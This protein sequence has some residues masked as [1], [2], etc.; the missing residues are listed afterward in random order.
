MGLL[1]IHKDAMLFNDLSAAKSKVKGP[2][3]GFISSS[4]QIQ[5]QSGPILIQIVVDYFHLS[6]NPLNDRRSYAQVVG[7]REKKEVGRKKIGDLNPSKVCR[8]KCFVV[9][10]KCIEEEYKKNDLIMNNVAEEKLRRWTIPF[11]G[12][13]V[14]ST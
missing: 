10:G 1:H 14:R 6:A 5:S 11:R 4:R 2:E 3:N 13:M 12:T 8:G 7:K 9:I